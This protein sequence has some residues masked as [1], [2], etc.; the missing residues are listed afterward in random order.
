MGTKGKRHAGGPWDW[1]WCSKCS[2]Y[3]VLSAPVSPLSLMGGGS[4][5]HPGTRVWLFPQ[6]VAAVAQRSRTASPW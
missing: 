6:A 2:L 5:D 4:R 3:P 1:D